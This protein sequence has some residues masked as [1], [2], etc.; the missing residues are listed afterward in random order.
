MFFHFLP[1]F[2]LFGKLLLLFALLMVVPLGFAVSQH[3]EAEWPFITGLLVTAAC[4]LVMMLASRR[5]GQ[6]LR[7]RDGFVLVVLAWMMFPAFAAIPLKLA[8]PGLSVTDAY[9]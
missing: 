3:D 4:G 6:E 2:E 5:A 7:P 9:F 1:V 8:L